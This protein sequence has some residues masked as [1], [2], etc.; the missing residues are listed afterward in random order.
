MATIDTWH[1]KVSAA[2]PRRPEWST[3]EEMVVAQANRLGDRAAL[4]A[5]GR[6]P[7]TFARLREQVEKTRDQLWELG[8]GRGDIAASVLENGPDAATALFCVSSCATLAPLNPE[9]QQSECE[10]LFR[11]LTPKILLAQAGLPQPARDVAGKMGIPVV[12][13]VTMQEAGAFRLRGV[14]AESRSAR[15]G[16]PAQ[17]EDIAYIVTTSGTTARPKLA[18]LTH[19]VVCATV[20][21]SVDTLALTPVDRCLNFSPLFHVLGLNAGLLTPLWNSGSTVC[22][23]GFQ[24]Q[25]FFLWLEGFQPT[26]F[27]AVPTILQQILEHAPRHA[28]VLERAS[29]RFVRTA[30]APL[31]PSVAEGIETFFG[32]PLLQ[33]YGLSEAPSITAGSLTAERR[34]GSCG[35]ATCNEVVVVDGNG[36]PLPPGDTGEIVVRGPGVIEGYFRNMEATQAA[37]RAGWFHTGDVGHLDSDGYLFLT[38]RASDFINRGGE[39]I[40]PM[41]VE[42]VLLAHPAV[43]QALVFSVP[44]EKLGEDVAA[45]VVLR[46]GVSATEAGLQ[47]FA[48]GRLA[49][50]KLP[51][52][53][54]FLKELPVGPTGKVLRSQMRAYLEGATRSSDTATAQYVEPRDAREKRIAALFARALR[55]PRVGIHDNFFDLGGDSLAAAECAALF[56]EAFDAPALSSGVFLYA[57]T[58][59]LLAEVLADPLRLERESGILPIQ[60]QGNGIPLFLIAPGFETTR[61]GRHLGTD[62]RLFGIP[63]PAMPAQSDPRSIEQMACECVRALR[64]FRPAGPYALAGWCAAGVVALEMA[65]QLEREG[66]EVAFV[67]MFDVRNLFPPPLSA[68]HLAWVRFYQRCRRLAF[69]AQRWRAGL[70]NRLGGALRPGSQAPLA[71]TTQAL[72]RYQPR[73]WP[74]RMV[75][76]W[77]AEWPHGRYFD[78]GF[79]WNHLAPNG[80]VFHEVPGN[81]LT[82]LQ[83]PNASEIARVLAAELD[84]CSNPVASLASADRV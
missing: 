53:I 75:H 11:E 65:Q 14:G 20:A 54:V 30:G 43:S 72:L 18:A 84:R 21:T 68:P 83:E 12:D 35:R 57:P 77:A 24:P 10:R 1:N 80:F 63:I 50:H 64:R 3:L 7:L 8:V 79:G 2:R 42:Q 45:A 44:H 37:F 15:I 66:A 60:S 33:I 70:W 34:P 59:A 81:H 31:P 61:L 78:P 51:R 9:A 55:L 38:G 28:A 69:V 23:G 19:R 16:E 13:V 25:K 39:K 58:V 36:G 47:E 22:A 17:S 62:R 73:P 6:D 56:R 76:I 26:W 48:A 49:A 71:E 27:S 46:E 40:S 67:A 5:P 74:G 41:E 29:I 82:M 32:A 52:R 4:L